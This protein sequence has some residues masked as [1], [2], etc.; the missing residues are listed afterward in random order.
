MV[1]PVRSVS[2][3]IAILRLLS[4]R[5]E[6]LTLAQVARSLG[7]S[8]SSCLN[9]LKT[10]VCEG[11][12]RQDEGKRYSLSEAWVSC[13]GLA[14][15]RQAQFVSRV[16]ALLCR[17][18][19]QQTATVGLWRMSSPTRVE[20]IAL[21]E[22]DS[23]TRILLALGQRQPLGAGSVGRALAVGQ[24][25]DRTELQNRFTDCRWA[26]PL[27]FADFAAQVDQARRDGFAAD[28]GFAFAGVASVACFLAV[29][30]GSYCVSAS[31]FEGMRDAAEMHQLGT[32]LCWIAAT[33]EAAETP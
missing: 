16:Q 22:N 18:A 9:L 13:R 28:Q 15:D 27:D 24:D 30:S 8:P 12:V 33:I 10:L 3:A 2:H 5:S 25:I 23:P 19:R 26:R 17:F 29:K 4:G 32:G 11:A 7:L 20:L 14:E 21:G 6:A 31:V 1:G